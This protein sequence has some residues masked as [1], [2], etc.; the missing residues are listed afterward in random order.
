[1]SKPKTLQEF[2]DTYGTDEG[3]RMSREAVQL[4]DGYPVIEVGP[5]AEAWPTVV[6][7]AGDKTAVVQFMNVGEGEPDVQHLCID[8]HAFVDGKAARASVFG[9]E[10]GR[11]I[12][13]FT[14][15][16]TDGTSNSWPAASL[17]AV[18][19]GKQV[20]RPSPVHVHW[21]LNDRG[22][23]TTAG[24]WTLA[25]D[26]LSVWRLTGPES[27]PIG[28]HESSL[29]AQEVASGYV[30]DYRRRQ[31]QQTRSGWAEQLCGEHTTPHPGHRYDEAWVDG[32]LVAWR[33]C[34]GVP[35]KPAG[36]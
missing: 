30:K 10:N 26:W 33:Q 24:G 9:M 3:A 28:E 8:V 11:R 14:G 23:Y 17:V 20:E 21:E 27:H 25:D 16:D 29:K 18:L 6:V 12:E 15:D 34:P 4:H 32:V 22:E 36:Q 19:V 7:K 13:G 31:E 35:Q 2:L 5:I 1:M